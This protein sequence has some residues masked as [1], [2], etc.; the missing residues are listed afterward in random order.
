M[1][2]RNTL[3]ILAS[4]W[5]ARWGFLAFGLI[6]ALAGLV[7]RW[8]ARIDARLGGWGSFIFFMILIIYTLIPGAFYLG[9]GAEA[10]VDLVG[11]ESLGQMIITSP[12]TVL[13]VGLFF[14][15]FISGVAWELW[16]L[17]YTMLLDRAIPFSLELRAAWEE[18]GQKPGTHVVAE[19]WRTYAAHLR[20][21]KRKEPQEAS[22]P[23]SA[24]VTHL[25][26]RERP[27]AELLVSPLTRAAPPAVAIF[28]L[29]LLGV[30][31]LRPY[32]MRMVAHTVESWAVTISPERPYVTVPVKI[33]YQPR[34]L[35]ILKLYGAGSAMIYLTGP[36]ESQERIWSLEDWDLGDRPI[37][38]EAETS[39]EGLP[40]G[41]YTLHFEYRT[42]EKAELGYAYSQG[43]GPLPQILGLAE[44]IMIATPV[45]AGGIILAAVVTRASLLLRWLV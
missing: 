30:R 27:L 45:V 13:L 14:A 12:T 23:T 8:V 31:A 21:L 34:T 24:P 2:L 11:R 29:C 26:E 5:G 9:G 42:G 37:R 39:I 6:G 25:P 20:Q 38:Q 16:R 15:L 33:I 40:A 36:G 7:T 28:I 10:W 32:Q 18:M 22:P 44:G 17:S 19:E 4:L 41:D 35:R 43:G 3:N 1:L